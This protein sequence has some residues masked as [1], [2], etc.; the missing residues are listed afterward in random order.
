MLPDRTARRAPRK[1]SRWQ[2]ESHTARSPDRAQ[3]RRLDWHLRAAGIRDGSRLLDLGCGWGTLLSR[4][5]A[6]YDAAQ[7]V[8]LTQTIEQV[9]WIRAQVRDARIHVVPATWQNAGFEMQFDA[10]IAIGT[11]ERAARPGASSEDRC[12]SYTEFFEFCGRNLGPGGRLTIEFAGRTDILPAADE[13]PSLNQ[14]VP[15]SML[16]VLSEV[17]A[18]SARRFH[19]MRLEN[20]TD[21]YDRTLTAQ[22]SRIHAPGDGRG[23]RGRYRAQLLHHGGRPAN[24]TSEPRIT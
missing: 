2:N 20:A 1:A 21:D 17:L 22:P 11:L 7:A 4:A 19:L 10:V 12:R 8:G 5:V 13:K 16:P 24:Q 14:M 15:H 3:V 23:G 18:A 9:N 6:T